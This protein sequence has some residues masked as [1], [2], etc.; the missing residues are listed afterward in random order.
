MIKYIISLI[1]FCFFLSCPLFAQGA[2]PIDPIWTTAFG[3]KEHTSR[4]K[5][6]Q[7]YFD[8]DSNLII[9]GTVERDSSFND[10]MV[11]KYSR[12]GLKIWQKRY[13]SGKLE[14]F[15]SPI[16]LKIDNHNNIIILGGYAEGENNMNQPLIFKIDPGGNILWSYI[17]PDIPNSIILF[18]NISILENDA[19]R[20]IT[21]IYTNGNN[22]YMFYDFSPNGSLMNNAFYPDINKSGLK[23]TSV[24]KSSDNKGSLFV[25]NMFDNER[26]NSSF[27]LTEIAG[28]DIK[29]Y[30]LSLT[31]EQK[32]LLWDRHWTVSKS[33]ELGNFY[34]I[35]NFSEQTTGYHIIKITT[36]GK[37]YE[38]TSL[39]TDHFLAIENLCFK[40][41]DN[42]LVGRQTDETGVNRTFLVEL[43]SNLVLI[44]SKTLSDLANYVPQN[45]VCLNDS[46]Y[47][48]LDNETTG[49]TSVVPVNASL[50]NKGEYVMTFPSEYTF[51]YSGF[52]KKNNQNFIGG[53][54]LK[55][56]F[57][58]ADYLSETE[59][60][61]ESYSEG[62]GIK[63]LWDQIYTDE[64][65]SLTGCVGV[66]KNKDT[67]V[68]TNDA[69]GPQ[70]IWGA[71]APKID[72]LYKIDS[73]GNKLWKIPLDYIFFTNY[74]NTYTV[75]NRS[76]FYL[77]VSK[78]S[79]YYLLRISPDGKEIKESPINTPNGIFV[80]K[81]NHVYVD[82]VF[83]DPSYNFSNEYLTEFDQDFNLV[84]KREIKG[85]VIQLFNLGDNDSLYY[86]TYYPGGWGDSKFKTISL[87]VNNKL[88]WSSKVNMSSPYDDGYAMSDFNKE[89][90][91]LYFA[92]QY[93]QCDKYV[94]RLT[95]KNEYSY[96]E[97][98]NTMDD[99][100]NVKSIS[101]GNVLVN[102]GKRWQLYKE[103]LSKQS[104][105]IVETYAN[106]TIAR[107]FIFLV[108]AGD[109]LIFDKNMAKIGEVSNTMLNSSGFLI[110]KNLDFFNLSS[111]GHELNITYDY[112]LTGYQCKVGG[113]SKFELSKKINFENINP[114][115]PQFLIDLTV[116]KPNE[117]NGGGSSGGSGSGGG[118]PP[119]LVNE[120]YVQAMRHYMVNDGFVILRSDYSTNQM[121]GSIQLYNLNG[122]LI[123]SKPWLNGETSSRITMNQLPHGFYILCVRS[124]S[125]KKMVYRAK[126]I[127]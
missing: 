112:T 97:L 70:H 88:R 49:K 24:A 104:T 116:N 47:T 65:T 83:T 32:Q 25:F 60:Y 57:Q 98:G 82:H 106:S 118:T 35:D 100:Y 10:I 74:T 3:S 4:D 79:T 41:S 19:I 125:D 16:D 102:L 36:R 76:Y 110:D 56:K 69:L 84:V 29:S 43:D 105:R 85:K 2:L 94:Q 48:I 99:F 111:F 9:V 42:L 96:I 6:T 66:Y 126:I 113:L 121:P 21:F 108:N 33:D 8:A 92:S 59:F 62:N 120:V 38:Y 31:T 39:N 67:Y 95:L 61:I 68:L 71:F 20:L 18:S 80:D 12:T 91:T 7:M 107:D 101:N 103:D 77:V 37:F 11:Q 75:D 64:G 54:I 40:N 117:S 114:S 78:L 14:D 5:L 27:W 50:Q 28:S 90:G 81:N 63:K 109:I 73:L 15:D 93:A 52:L 87:Y 13:S 72:Y 30:D 86:Y 46:I 123:I 127:W 23:G 22:G 119:D 115:D 89:T 44:N 51:F 124:Q 53:T 26:N 17:I 34:F 45:I 58:G 122:E 1:I 55:P